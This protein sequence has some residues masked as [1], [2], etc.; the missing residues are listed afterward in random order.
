MEIA[1][2]VRNCYPHGCPC[3]FYNAPIKECSCCTSIPI[4]RSQKKIST[5]LLD[6]IDIHVEA[7]PH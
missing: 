3:G 2:A 5:P 1:E 7:S 4:S 6:R